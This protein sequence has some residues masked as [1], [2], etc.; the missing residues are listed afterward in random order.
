MPPSAAQHR[1]AHPRKRLHP[2]ERFLDAPVN[3]PPRRIARMARRP[4][5]NGRGPAAAPECFGR[6]G[7]S[8]SGCAAHSRSRRRH[9]PCRRR[10]S[11]RR[12]DRRRLRSRPARAGARRG[13]NCRA[14]PF[15]RQGDHCPLH[16]KPATGVRFKSVQQLAQFFRCLIECYCLILSA[17][18]Y[19]TRLAIQYSLNSL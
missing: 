12:G 13:W 10:A 3:T 17:L 5:I 7:A 4:P 18:R 8:R 19:L 2:A 14:Y 1:P 11:L 6:R 9:I 16:A 15:R